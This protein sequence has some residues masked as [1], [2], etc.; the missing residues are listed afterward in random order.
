MKSGIGIGFGA[1][2]GIG[3]ALILFR[4]LFLRRQRHISRAE[5]HARPPAATQWLVPAHGQFLRS[6]PV[7]MSD[8]VPTAP[9]IDG[10]LVPTELENGGLKKQI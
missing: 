1:A 10:R 8:M 3:I 2:F 7:E 5:G 9:E 4:F 6:E